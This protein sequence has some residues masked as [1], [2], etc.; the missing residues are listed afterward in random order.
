MGLYIKGVSIPKRCYDCYY[1]KSSD[2]QDF[3]RCI[4]TDIDILEEEAEET[5]HTACPMV[6]VETPHGPLKDIYAIIHGEGRY[7]VKLGTEAIDIKEILRAKTVIEPEKQ[8]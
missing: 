7:I 3:C 5:R 8:P 4:L 6:D 1:C 2:I